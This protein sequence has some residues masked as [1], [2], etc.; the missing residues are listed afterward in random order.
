MRLVQG[1]RTRLFY[2]DGGF[3]QMQA[4]V[5]GVLTGRAMPAESIDPDL[6]KE[7][8]AAAAARPAN[9]PDLLAIRDRL[10]DQARAQLWVARRAGR[11]T[12]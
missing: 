9:T 8:L 10:I 5:V 4:D 11:A 1:G 6:A 3:V 12:P 7:Q 2:V